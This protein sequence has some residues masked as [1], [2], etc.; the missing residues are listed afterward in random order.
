MSRPQPVIGGQP[1]RRLNAAVVSPELA[2]MRETLT[3]AG[4]EWVSLAIDSRLG[5]GQDFAQ[6]VAAQLRK[7][8]HEAT[9]RGNVVWA[10]VPDDDVDAAAPAALH[11]CGCGAEFDTRAR[12]ARHRIAEDH[13]QDDEVDQ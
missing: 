10:R 11:Q 13:H 5:R 4:G 9:S 2:A 1:P 7:D 8:G 12:L 6:R 3:K